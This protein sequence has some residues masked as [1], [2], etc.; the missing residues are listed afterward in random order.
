MCR[1]ALGLY[2]VPGWTS[3]M[4]AQC[5]IGGSILMGLGMVGSYVARIFEEVKGRPLYVVAKSFN[6]TRGRAEPHSAIAAPFTEGR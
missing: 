4:V 1:V 5:I 2:V 3:L 6:V